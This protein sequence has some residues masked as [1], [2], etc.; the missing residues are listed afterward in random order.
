MNRMSLK[1]AKL[2]F[3][4]TDEGDASL[5]ERLAHVGLNIH[6]AFLDGPVNGINARRTWS[7]DHLVLRI[8]LCGEPFAEGARKRLGGAAQ[9]DERFFLGDLLLSRRRPG[10]SCHALRN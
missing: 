7:G 10:R 3:C 6:Q 2:N 1:Y 9:L 4:A 8:G 5:R